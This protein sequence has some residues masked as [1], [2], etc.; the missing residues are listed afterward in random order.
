MQPH[1]VHTLAPQQEAEYS[2]CET[3]A[4]G[5][6]IYLGDTDGMLTI[7]DTRAPDSTPTQ[8]QLSHRKLNTLH[9]HPQ[10]PHLITAATS[11]GGVSVWDARTWSST[12][13]AAG[14]KRKSSSPTPLMTGSHRQ[15]CQSA[16]FSPLG[17]GLIVST[18]RDNTVRIWDAQAGG[19]GDV[20]KM[21]E[22]KHHNND[23]GRW[24]VPFRAVWGPG[25]DCVLVG[26]MGRAVDVLGV[27]AGATSGRLCDAEYMT[28][29]PSRNIVHPSA[30]LLAASTGSGRVHVYR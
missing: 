15:T 5:N 20:L 27:G 25:G 26:N 29:I 12:P 7:I 1:H 4:D 13:S 14:S 3:D 16:Y 23:T 11:D 30:P 6:V 2:C 9:M 28:A 19:K 24:I 10:Q 8:L 21:V 18:S 22:S 17:D